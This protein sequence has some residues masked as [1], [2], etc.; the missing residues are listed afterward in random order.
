M[1]CYFVLHIHHVIVGL[2]I[3]ACT[4]L[5]LFCNG[6]MSGLLTYNTV[7]CFNII[8]CVIIV[9]CCSISYVSVL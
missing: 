7:L 8:F 6:L 5:L 2:T 1:Y 4:N 3:L 9:Y